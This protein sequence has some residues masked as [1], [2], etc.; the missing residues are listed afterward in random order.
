MTGG[1]ATVKTLAKKLRPFSWKGTI[2]KIRI[3][4]VKYW[5][6]ASKILKFTSCILKFACWILKLINLYK[7]THESEIDWY[8]F[9]IHKYKFI[10]WILKF[11]SFN[12]MFTNPLKFKLQF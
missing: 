1:S 8:K 4:Q 11:T 2:D 5:N 7:N 6:F 3:V 9:K 12:L 10:N